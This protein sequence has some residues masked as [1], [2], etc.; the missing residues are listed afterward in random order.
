[1]NELKVLK[2]QVKDELEKLKRLLDE[3][4]EISKKKV[5]NINIRAGGSVLH[6][7]YTGIEKIFHAIVSTID[8][9]VPNVYKAV[10]G[11]LNKAFEDEE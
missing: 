11:D 1:M 7:F 2:S 9:K 10:E 6:D 4:S 3:A 8:E 5:S